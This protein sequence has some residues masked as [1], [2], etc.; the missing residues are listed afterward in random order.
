MNWST[1]LA[2]LIGGGGIG[3]L[4]SAA[5]T[6]MSSKESNEID[7]LDRAYEEI[8]RLDEIIDELKEE[9]GNEREDNRELE[10]IIK[11]LEDKIKG[12][13]NKIEENERKEAK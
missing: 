12:L 3:T 7:L 11:K 8:R 10:R 4:I 2:L 9:L 13:L 6:R 5:F 1:A